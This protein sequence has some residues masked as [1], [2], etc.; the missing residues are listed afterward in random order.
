M[1]AG[2]LIFEGEKE[3]K[4]RACYMS[5]PTAAR[6]RGPEDHFC[7]VWS[8]PGTSLP[9]KMNV[10]VLPIM[11]RSVRLRT[12]TDRSCFH[13]GKVSLCAVA[14]K[15][16][17]KRFRFTAKCSV[18]IPDCRFCSIKNTSRVLLIN[19]KVKQIAVEMVQICS[20]LPTSQLLVYCAPQ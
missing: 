5:E 6:S 3:H 4:W 15:K 20:V 14:R 10:P 19:H 7:H 1:S 16:K 17:K 11:E 13:V 12:G 9:A 18:H 8:V 2:K